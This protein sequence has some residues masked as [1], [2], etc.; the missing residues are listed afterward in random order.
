M[1]N[2]ASNFCF[3]EKQSL[4]NKQTTKNQTKNPQRSQ[5]A[6]LTVS[7][8]VLS[9]PQESS[10]V[11]MPTDLDHREGRGAVTML[12]LGLGATPSTALLGFAFG[13][14]AGYAQMQQ[15]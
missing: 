2:L 13:A 7:R 9:S 1:A 4:K 14:S 15:I 5:K 12:Q 6:A 10:L 3:S 8:W 11:V